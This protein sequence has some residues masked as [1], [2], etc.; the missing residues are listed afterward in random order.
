MN[1]KVAALVV[2]YNRLDLL[3]EVIDAL[4]GQ[5]YSQLSIVVVN[6]GSTDDTAQWLNS[7]S[8]VTTITQDN[9]GGAGGFNTGM[10]YI[11]EHNYDACW[12]MDDDVVCSPDALKELLN[13]LQKNDN[14]GFVCSKVVGL[15]GTPMNVPMVDQRKRG[16]NYQNWMDYLEYQM[17]GV[18]ACTFVSVLIPTRVIKEV[19]LPYKE[20][21]IWGD[22]SEYTTRITR[23]Y[24][25]FMAAK[26]VVTHKRAIQ[27]DL[28]FDT[29]TNAT[30][31]NNF[32]YYFR[33]Q[34]HFAYLYR[35]RLMYLKRIIIVT[36][37]GFKMLFTGKFKKAKVAFHSQ[38]NALF[39]R[40]NREQVGG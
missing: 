10:R 29:E 38:A 31:I 28:R 9:T 18:E 7:Q 30:R 34:T 21:F 15:D 3:K 32:F 36:L 20:Y 6:N 1:Y 37:L 12:L 4:R 14:I 40:P 22:D 19:G 39:F 23:K 17:V 8:D 2:T 11:A 16:V 26:S 35:G 13:A 33:N 25:A 27:G 5:T 24:S